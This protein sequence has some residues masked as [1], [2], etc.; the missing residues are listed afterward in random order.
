MTRETIEK[1]FKCLSEHIEQVRALLAWDQLKRAE[2]RPHVPPAFELADPTPV[3][4]RNRIS[5]F[6]VQAQDLRDLIADRRRALL[7]PNQSYDYQQRLVKLED[8][9]RRLTLTETFLKL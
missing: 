6:W 2:V 7:S 8:Q 5:S 4:L 3:E 1:Y 9:L